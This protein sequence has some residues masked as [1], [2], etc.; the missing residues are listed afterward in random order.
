MIIISSANLQNLLYFSISYDICFR[1]FYFYEIILW[2]FD[3][4]H[5]HAILNERILVSNWWM[6]MNEHYHYWETC[7]K[8]YVC[9]VQSIQFFCQNFSFTL[10]GPKT[11]E[12][13]SNILIPFTLWF[14]DMCFNRKHYK[15]TLID[16][17]LVPI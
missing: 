9:I 8:R 4:I 17:R 13:D 10:F 3:P 15:V 1:F 7:T 14:A 12:K 11:L 2:S 5:F 16:Q 6:R